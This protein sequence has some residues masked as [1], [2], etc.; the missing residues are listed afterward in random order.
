VG[1]RRPVLDRR[2]HRDAD[3]GRVAAHLTRELVGKAS[4]ASVSYDYWIVF[5]LAEG[6]ITRAEFVETRGH[7][8]QTAGVRQ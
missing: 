3:N 8:L 2:A 4:G 5:T 1:G 7:A 6:T